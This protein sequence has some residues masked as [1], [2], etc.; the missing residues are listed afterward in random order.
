[1]SV[2]V[3]V[4]VVAIISWV[5]T[6]VGLPLFHIYERYAWAPQMAMLF[7]L[8]GCAGPYFDVST[9][10]QGDSATIAGN[11]LS[12]LSLSLSAC[13]AWAPAGADYYVYYPERTPKRL[14]FILTYIGENLSEIFTFLMGAGIA[15][16][17]MNNPTWSAANDISPGAVITA[18]FSPLGSFGKFCAVIMA[19]GVI[20]NNIPGTYSAGLGFQCLGSWPLRVPRM[21]WNTFGVAVYTA[22]AAAGRDHLFEIFEN[23]LA[24]MGY[25]VCIWI[26]ITLQ[27]QWIFRNGVYDWSHWN[28]RT[29]LPI[30]LAA[31]AAF[32]IGWVGAVLCMDQIYFVG[33]ISKMVGE[34]GSDMGIFVGSAWAGLVYPP[35]RWIEL[36]FIGR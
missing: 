34:F 21:V 8:I 16:G 35:L 6:V 14:T 23:F 18:G 5:I 27:E 2:V 11:R 29:K 10:S 17:I 22:C 9:P 4:V 25:W 13:S 28:D 31:L 20:A 36:K 33:P 26:V 15:S 7:I 32:C 19:L 12:F 24:L 3:G 30:G 1:M